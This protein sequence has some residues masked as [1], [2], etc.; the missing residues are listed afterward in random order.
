MLDQAIKGNTGRIEFFE[1]E[2]KAFTAKDATGEKARGRRRSPRSRSYQTFLETKLA[3]RA[4]GDWRLGAELYAKKFP[5]ALQTALTPDQVVPRA[6]QAFANAKTKLYAVARKLHGQLW[7][8]ERC[9]RRTRAPR[10]RRRR[11]SA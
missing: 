8:K 11:S 3:K 10:S 1:T 5:L 6:E 9:R 4:D 7:P 2:V